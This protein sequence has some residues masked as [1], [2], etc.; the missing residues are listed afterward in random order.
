[1]LQPR[2]YSLSEE[3]GVFRCV[4]LCPPPPPPTARSHP[5]TFVAKAKFRDDGV[6]GC[7]EKEALHDSAFSLIGPGGDSNPSPPPS[8]FADSPLFSYCF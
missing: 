1:M 6:M 8:L 2:Y 7:G 3:E 4:C 5:S